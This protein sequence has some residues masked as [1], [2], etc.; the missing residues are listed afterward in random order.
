M[1]FGIDWPSSFRVKMFENN[2]Y[3]HVYSTG[4]GADNPG[5][6]L[7]SLILL[8]SQYS[9]LLQVFPIK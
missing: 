6:K 5:G 3:I 1:K 4:A 8:F 7:F 2:G 9:P